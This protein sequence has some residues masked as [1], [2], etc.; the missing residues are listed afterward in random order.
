MAN[1]SARHAGTKADCD[2]PQAL[3]SV[4]YAGRYFK[5]EPFLLPEKLE[6]F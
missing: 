1:C 6:D 4:E 5:E 3:K 2:E